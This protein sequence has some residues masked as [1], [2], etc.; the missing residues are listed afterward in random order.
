MGANPN[1]E[2]AEL[3][4]SGVPQETPPQ[5]PVPLMTLTILGA[6][7]R[8]TISLEGEGQTQPSWS[9]NEAVL[10]AEGEQARGCL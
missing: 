10:R 3:L 8:S 4:A 5:V 6:S 9:R 1:P 2:W 7:P